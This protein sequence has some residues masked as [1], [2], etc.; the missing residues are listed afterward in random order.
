MN[1]ND[2]AHLHPA[3][4]YPKSGRQHEALD[5][6]HVLLCMLEDHVAGHPFVAERE[7]IRAT[8]Q[9]AIDSLAQAYQLIG[10]AE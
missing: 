10:A 7:E 4:P 2:A 1:P 5:R 3:H 8:V 9:A 6:C